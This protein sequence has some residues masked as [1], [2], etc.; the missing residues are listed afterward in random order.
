MRFSSLAVAS[1]SLSALVACG[2]DGK[3]KVDGSIHTIDT[4]GGTNCV[5]AT[6]QASYGSATP[7]TADQSASRDAD[8]NPGQIIYSAKAN[9]D[10]M[11][12]I[13]DI[14]LFKGSGTFTTGELTA[15][16]VNLSDAAEAQYRTCGACF[17][18]RTDIH[19]DGSGGST[20][21]DDY[22]AKSGT[23][24]ITTLSP[25]A[26]TITNAVL[27]HVTIAADFTSTPVG[28]CEVTV[29]SLT[30]NTPVTTATQFTGGGG[31]HR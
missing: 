23:L 18:I 2:G 16:T 31:R 30:F 7:A 15:K 24:T 11:F 22:M 17:L 27:T 25:F 19:S 13:F 21:T 4:P 29:D 3:S 5:G 28:D 12:D 26:G 10:P 20:S 14:E 9:Q 6:A 8:T 1:L